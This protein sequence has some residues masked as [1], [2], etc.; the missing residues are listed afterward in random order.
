L[1]SLRPFY[2]PGGV[3]TWHSPKISEKSF[4]SGQINHGG[5]GDHGEA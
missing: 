5:H 4:Q 3:K 1:I 2:H